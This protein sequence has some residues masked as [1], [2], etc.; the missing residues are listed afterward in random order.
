MRKFLLAAGAIALIGA[1]P[2]LAAGEMSVATFLA[3][4]D[5]L[6]AKGFGA[7]G[8]PDIK[9]LRTEA[10]AAGATYRSRM[11]ADKK[12]GR[13]PHSCPPDK[14]KMTSDQFMT[15]LRSYPATARP[16]TSV[17]TAVFDLMKKRYPCP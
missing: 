3:K 1:S 10:E 2:V 15:H 9:L 12:A 11:E 5:A 7:L 14:T 16:K 4:A 8:S 6:K 13:P 17:T